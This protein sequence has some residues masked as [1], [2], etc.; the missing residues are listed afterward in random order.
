MQDKWKQNIMY[1]VGGGV[2]CPYINKVSNAKWC[3]LG[4]QK[5]INIPN[6]N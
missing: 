5:L 6:I 2:Q 3:S 1:N 4:N